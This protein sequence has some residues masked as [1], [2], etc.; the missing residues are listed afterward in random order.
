MAVGWY[1]NEDEIYTELDNYEKSFCVWGVVGFNANEEEIRKCCDDYSASY[2]DVMMMKD[3]WQHKR[4]ITK[5]N[6]RR[7]AEKSNV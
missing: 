3:Y 7:K 4:E 1:E 5:E 6:K 2:E